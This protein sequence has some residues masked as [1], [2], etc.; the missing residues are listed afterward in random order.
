MK[1]KN[2]TDRINRRKFVSHVATGTVMAFGMGVMT[3]RAGAIGIGPVTFSGQIQTHSK[4]PSAP[5]ESGG[6]SF[7]VSLN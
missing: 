2:K 6:I 4:D 1:K 7:P 5:T 3:P